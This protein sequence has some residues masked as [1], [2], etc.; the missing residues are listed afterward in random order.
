MTRKYC[1]DSNC[2]NFAGYECKLGFI[3]KFRAPM[4]YT[5]I[6]NCDWGFL[7][8]KICQKGLKDLT[9]EKLEDLSLD[10]EVNG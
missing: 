5:D 6:Q 8:P 7:M 2:P 1:D 4:S 3:V 9:S 10:G